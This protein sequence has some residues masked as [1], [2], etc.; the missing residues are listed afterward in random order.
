M[1]INRLQKGNLAEILCGECCM[2]RG[3]VRCQYCWKY[4]YASLG[5]SQQ[6]CWYDRLMIQIKS[7]EEQLSSFKSHTWAAC[8][9][10]RTACLLPRAAYWLLRAVWWLL[11]VV[12][13]KMPIFI[14]HVVVV[15]A[16]IRLTSRSLVKM[17]KQRNLQLLSTACSCTYADLAVFRLPVTSILAL[18]VD[19]CMLH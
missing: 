12:C 4:Y 10:L 1:V 19:S 17:S 6:C 2:V 5:A 16:Y 8:W 13:T 9:L 18:P 15:A 14:K 3:R 7:W 11:I